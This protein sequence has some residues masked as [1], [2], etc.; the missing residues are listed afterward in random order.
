MHSPL[1]L[2]SIHRHH[3]SRIHCAG[4]PGENR[5]LCT[6]VEEVDRGCSPL[7]IYRS[8]RRCISTRHRCIHPHSYQP[9]HT[10][11][12]NTCTYLLYLPTIHRT[13]YLLICLPI[14]V[15][16]HSDYLSLCRAGP[17]KIYGRHGDCCCWRM[18][19]HCVCRSFRINRVLSAMYDYCHCSYQYHTIGVDISLPFIE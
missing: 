9:P 6:L 3:H 18:C 12:P 15:V 16:V 13:I 4:L 19:V 11:F 10:L 1:A 14:P 2:I 7:I 5:R 17:A 8:G